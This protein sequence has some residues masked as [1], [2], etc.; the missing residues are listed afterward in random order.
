M[1]VKVLMNQRH[2]VSHKKQTETNGF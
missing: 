2:W 1:I